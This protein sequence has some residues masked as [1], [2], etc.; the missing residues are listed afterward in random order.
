MSGFKLSDIFYEQ[1]VGKQ[2]DWPYELS[3]F[4]Y[5]RTYARYLESEERTEEFYETCKRVVEAVFT[6][7][8]RHCNQ[9]GLPW[10]GHK[11]QR[12]A[13]RMFELMFEF[14]FLP[15]G[16][17]LANFH[18]PLIDKI[19]GACLNNCA[20]VSTENIHKGLGAPFAWVC[21]ML[22]NGVGTGYNTLGAGKLKLKSPY[23]EPI[24][25]Q[26]PDSR[27][28]WAESVKLLLDS[29]WQG[30]NPIRF[31]YSLLRKAG[32][33][34]KTF[35]G[36]A[37]GPEVLKSGHENIRNILNKRIDNLIMSTDI[38]DIMDLIGVFVVSGGTRRSAE[39]ALSHIDDKDF[40]EMKDPTKFSD[41]LRDWRWMSNNS[42][43]ANPQSNFTGIINNIV[44]NGEP[45]IIFLENARAHGRFKD[46]I[47]DKNQDEYDGG[48]MGFNPCGEQQLES[49]ELCTLCETFPANHDSPE[50]YLEET[51]KFAYL[52][53]K[54][55]TLIP[56][57][58]QA[59]NQVMMRN[60]RI[61][62]SQSG[63]QQ[64][65]KKFGIAKYLSE[66]CDKSY[67]VVKHWDRMYSR[68]LGIPTSIRRTT[69]KP[70]GSISLLAGATPGVHC[71]HSEF[72]LRT[73]RVSINDPL[74]KN[75]IKANYRVEISNTDRKSFEK[76]TQ[77]LQLDLKWIDGF[78]YIDLPKIL[79]NALKDE[80]VTL[81]AYF[82]IK[83]KLFTKSKF[84]I[85]LWEQLTI[86][87]E[88]Q[89]FW[90]DNAVSCTITFKEHEI[91]DL[92]SAIQFFAPYVK[93]LS[94]LP[95]TNHRYSQA[96][97]QE[98]SEKEYNDY[99]KELK[100]LDLKS[101]A[102]NH[103]E[104]KYCNNDTCVI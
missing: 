85:S 68:W 6:I 54:T 31:D 5:K 65:I 75:L 97:Y 27:E 60:R 95:L 69:I 103:I 34:I 40:I 90:S 79:I 74:V 11:A 98:C 53:A 63:I 67:D 23:G 102:I 29:Y 49:Y 99:L 83:E 25:F 104:E 101:V 62:L 45:G 100:P 1:Y 36:F 87:K 39:L 50:Q 22:M 47:L 89:H 3:Y 86:V 18:L 4:T 70:S 59:T 66:F 94:F 84:D 77:K 48:V 55:I 92:E 28:G 42:V 7:Q 35:G 76:Q 21:E 30:S 26:I 52:Y 8:R 16:R 43:V 91:K 38:V 10:D 82:P 15:P 58:S 2:P 80:A 41:E 17:G 93:T 12:S 51:L 71:T 72:Y 61:G 9:F 73:I 32:A 33:R 81:V 13:Q 37:S 19:G 57:H 56:T 78:P 24:I 14:K 20:F 96:P 46:G 44:Q 64:A 88:L